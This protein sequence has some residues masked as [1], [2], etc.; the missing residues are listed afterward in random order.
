MVNNTGSGLKEVYVCTG[1]T[2][3]DAAKITL[4]YFRVLGSCFFL[5]Y[6][7]NKFTV[8]FILIVFKE[9]FLA[10]NSVG[11]SIFWSMFLSRLT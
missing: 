4:D 9:L 11:T 10:T 2:D 1:L 8:S 5:I 3:T 7:L 6:F